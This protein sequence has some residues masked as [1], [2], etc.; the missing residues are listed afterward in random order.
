MNEPSLAEIIVQ[1]IEEDIGP[2]GEDFL[3]VRDDT[4]R[5]SGMNPIASFTFTWDGQTAIMQ[6][7]DPD[8]A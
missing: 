4:M 6:I 7:F 2:E 8:A 1:T 5:I 3:C